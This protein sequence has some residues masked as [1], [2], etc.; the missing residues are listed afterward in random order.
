MTRQGAL[1]LVLAVLA[2]QPAVAE[3]YHRE[4]LRIAMPAAGPRGLEALLIRPA[5][6]QAYPLALISHGTA[7]D[8]E[9]RRDLTPYRFYQQ[10]VAFARRGFAALVVMRRGYGDSGGTHAE[11]AGCCATASILRAESMAADDLRA[12]VAAM[13][14]R[15][16]ISSHGMIAIGVSTGGLATIALTTNPPPGLAAAISFAGGIRRGN[17]SDARKTADQAGLVDAFRTLGATSHAPMLWIYAANDSYFSPELAGQAFDAFSAAGGRAQLIE[18]PAFG[19]DGHDLFHGGITVWQP[20]VDAF[21]HQQNLGRSIP[22]A[23]PLLPDLP[24]P[25]QF[26]SR[27]RAAFSEYMAKG[28]HKAFAVSPKNFYGYSAG[29]RSVEDAKQRALSECGKLAPDCALYAVDDQLSGPATAATEP[30]RP[31]VPASPPQDRR[32]R[33]S[34]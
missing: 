31:D 4:D 8:A 11:G 7:A 13:E 10:A 28:Q 25:P 18:A 19:N 2:A 14:H 24:V 1:W 17:A 3:D 6:A 21:L 9:E 29:R 26:G 20:M 34:P 12:A 32:D 27:G 23:A 22:L 5:G 33:R 30:V 16:D 15:P